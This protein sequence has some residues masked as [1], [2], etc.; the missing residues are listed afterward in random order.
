MLAVDIKIKAHNLGANIE[1]D[2]DRL[3]QELAYR[4]VDE[5]RTLIDSSTPAGRV[6]R[7]GSF[8]RRHSRGFG[9]RASGAGRRFHRAS[10]HGQPPAEDTGRTYWDINVS[11]LSSGRYRVRFGGVAGYLEFG[12]SR[13]RPRPYILPAIE[14]AVRKVFDG[15]AL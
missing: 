9:Q 8:G 2:I 7:R 3:E 15:S 10:A 5:A 14:N 6:Y 13:M 4:I 1:K 11:R 12:T